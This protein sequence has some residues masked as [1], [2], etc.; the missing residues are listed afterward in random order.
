V[1]AHLCVKQGKQVCLMK[2]RLPGAAKSSKETKAERK[3]T[4]FDH[5][6]GGHEPTGRDYSLRRVLVNRA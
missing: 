6:V 5:L 2:A 3:S 1:K 4:L